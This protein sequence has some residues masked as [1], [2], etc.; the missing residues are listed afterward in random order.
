[1]KVSTLCLLL[2]GESPGEVLLGFKKVGFGRGKVTGF[3]GKLEQG[4][5]EAEAAV[6]EMEEET[7]VKV[8][9]Q[10]LVPMAR[11]SFHFPAR[12]GWSQ[13][14]HVFVARTWEGTAAEGREMRPI[15]FRADSLPFDEMWQDG[16]HWL[17]PVLAG[18]R[19]RG[20]FTF[21]ADNETL[22]QARIETWDGGQR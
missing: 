19:I 9:Q 20:W 7:G 22:E 1:M 2:R 8:S 13:E 15:W 16:A 11:L 5:T 21:G 12:P 4:E 14:V 6:R 18:R 3:G 17:P 10:D